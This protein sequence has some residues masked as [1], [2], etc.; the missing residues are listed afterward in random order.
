MPVSGARCTWRGLVAL[1][2]AALVGTLA[3]ACAADDPDTGPV[4][5]AALVARSCAACHGPDLAGTAVGPS[6]LIDLYGPAQLTDQAIV[7]A[8]RDGVPPQRFSFG[9][10]PMIA[11]LD[12]D[13]V[14]AIVAHVRAL[15]AAAGID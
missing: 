6:L 1:V 3:S 5:G 8:I 11:G 2:G 4:D 7:D 14:A 15:Q 13:E 12:D 9:P 10:M